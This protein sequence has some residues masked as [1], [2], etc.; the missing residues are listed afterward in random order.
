[1]KRKQRYVFFSHYF[2]FTITNKQDILTN[3]KLGKNKHD[4]VNKTMGAAIY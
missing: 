4:S 3:V 1:M 2:E